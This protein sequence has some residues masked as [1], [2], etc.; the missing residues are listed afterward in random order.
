M[1]GNFGKE[2]IGFLDKDY[3]ARILDSEMSSIQNKLYVF[4]N[5]YVGNKRK[6]I[7][8]FV[9]LLNR[10]NIKFDVFLDLFC[11]SSFVSMAMKM[12]NK[13]VICNDILDSAF[14]NA[15]AFVVNKDMVLTDEEKKFLVTNDDKEPI[16]LFFNSYKDRFTENEIWYLNN[17]HHNLEILYSSVRSDG[18]SHMKRSLAFAYLQ[19]YVLEH[20]FV[21]GRLSNNQVLAKL[22]HRLNHPRNKGREM[23]FKNIRWTNPIYPNDS[24]RHQAFGMDAINFLEQLEEMNKE[25]KKS[26]FEELNPDLCYIDPPYGG[27]QSDYAEMYDFFEGYIYLQSRE[28]RE[29]I[30]DSYNEEAKLSVK[31]NL[32]NKK[33]FINKKNYREHFDKLINLTAGIKWIAIS[34]NNSSWGSI[35]EIHEIVKRYRKRVIIEDF[36]YS[37]NYRKKGNRK[38]IKEYLILAEE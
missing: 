17:Y 13:R 5:P 24:N 4:K 23:S 27:H 21:G 18:L 30:L 12:L 7:S 28:E 36:S 26:G 20:C 37:Y 29:K 3:S 15:L 6:L 1:K 22:D 10:Y 33:R 32:E 11:G 8:F 38:K 19:N 25:H 9:P 35:D 2:C 34:Y 14:L 16:H 31:R